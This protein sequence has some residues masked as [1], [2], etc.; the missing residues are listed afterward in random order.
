MYIGAS[1]TPQ[2]D[3][4]SMYAQAIQLFQAAAATAVQMLKAA[5]TAVHMLQAAAS[6]APS[7]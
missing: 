7:C 4:T 2:G 1:L 5:G 3:T 6:D